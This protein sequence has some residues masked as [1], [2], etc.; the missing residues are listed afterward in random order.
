ML[1]LNLS[2]FLIVSYNLAL[3]FYSITDFLMK[4]SDKALQKEMTRRSEEFPC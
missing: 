1:S 2:V 3:H 4:T